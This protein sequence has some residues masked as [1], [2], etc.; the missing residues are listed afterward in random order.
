MLVEAIRDGK[1][2]EEALC[3]EATWQHLWTTCTG[4]GSPSK[5]GRSPAVS[6]HSTDVPKELTGKLAKL[7]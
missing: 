1:M 4:G 6:N 7:R 5:G 2:L 3:A